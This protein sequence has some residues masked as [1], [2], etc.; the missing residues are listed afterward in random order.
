MAQM[1]PEWRWYAVVNSRIRDRLPTGRN[2]IYTS[3]S[4]TDSSAWRTRFWYESG[5]PRLLREVGADALFSLTNYL[6]TRKLPCPALLLVQHA[7]HFSLDF[8]QLHLKRCGKWRGL[9]WKIKTRWVENSVRH[10]TAV[11]VQ[12]K[13]LANRISIRTGRCIDDIVVVPHAA[14]VSPDRPQVVRGP[15]A[16][17]PVRIAYVTKSGVQKNFRILFA[18]AARLRQRGISSVI[19]LTLAHESPQT[20]D[21]LDEAARLGVSDLIENHGECSSDDLDQTYRSTHIFVFPSLCESFGLPMAEA[22]AYGIPL[23]VADVDSNLEVAGQAGI[24]FLGDNADALACEIEKLVADP[25]R[26]SEAA[27]RSLARGKELS[28]EN[29]ST[30]TLEIIEGL[31]GEAHGVSARQ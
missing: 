30:E 7:G 1:R 26:F 21:I 14:G 31:L 24:P 19:V 10:A 3:C 8:E 25:V 13:A 17:A 20:A 18:A 5:L 2:V 11:T 23:C 29:A 28:W 15:E 12:T 27:E 6:P 22:M 4:T 16:G 9:H